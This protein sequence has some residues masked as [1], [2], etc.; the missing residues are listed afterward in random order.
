[1]KEHSARVKFLNI[2]IRAATLCCRFL[3][4]FFLAKL[5]TPSEVGLYGLVTATVAYSLYFVGLDFY[6]Y[7]TRELASHS[8]S[9]WGG[10]LK[11]QIA[12]SLLLYAVVLPALLLVF[13][14]ELLPWEL[15]K[16]FFL[17][18]VLEHICQELIRLFVAVS[19]Q[20]AA[21]IVLFLRQGTWAIVIVV[22]MLYEEGLRNLDA[23]F[24]TWA[25]ACVVAIAFSIRKLGSMEVKGWSA[26]IDREWIWRG[27]KIAVPLLVATLAIRGIFTVD[28]YW[29]QLLVGLEI[30]GAYV[31]FIGVASTLMSFLD[32]GVFSF[33]YPSMI[34]AYQNNEP[35]RY[36]KKMREMLIL[37]LLFSFGFSIVSVILLPY[38]LDWLGKDIYLQN[39]SLFYWLLLA[40]ILNALGMVPH[41]AVYS[42]KRD[43]SIIQ[44]HL[45]ALPVFI[46]VTAIMSVWEPLLAVPIGLCASQ[47]FIIV[48]KAR[49]YLQCT[50]R[51]F[52]GIAKA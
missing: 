22:A 31:L 25:V 48:W 16:W 44:S 26:R 21:S 14:S 8:R 39:Y 19:E 7:T 28:R 12:L 52:L 3:F 50:P 29:V 35:V 18:I 10:L 11:N 32:A 24:A 15:A 51:P 42:Q 38:L 33:A 1:M 4:I 47:L 20:L 37:T 5:L 41:Y 49:A 34:A 36:R 6:T 27:I 30:V 13:A 2:T 9:V 45:A 40:T 17:L 23:V 46:V 43:R